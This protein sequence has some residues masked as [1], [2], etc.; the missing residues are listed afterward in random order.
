MGNQDIFFKKEEYLFNFRVCGVIKSENK[1]LLHKKKEDDFW[2]L[3][4]GR[5]KL[6]ED[7][8]QAMVREIK[9]EL[10]LDCTVKKELKFSENF[11][12]FQNH[13]YH[14]ILLVYL[15]ELDGDMKDMTVEKDL[16]VRWFTREEIEKI[17]IK[18]PFF[19]NILLGSDVSGWRI[20]NNELS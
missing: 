3:M 2:N 10:G 6:G 9:E 20:L 15:V 13:R 19:K 7:S 17:A 12:E 5:V 1:F 16:A 18:P 8:G 11:F 14:E 4:G